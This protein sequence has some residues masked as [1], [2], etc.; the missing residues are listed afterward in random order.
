MGRHMA[1]LAGAT[2]DLLALDARSKGGDF[3]VHHRGWS[4]F[5]RVAFGVRWW[6][7]PRRRR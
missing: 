5:P 4:I 2:A 7:S 3:D 6:P 1:F